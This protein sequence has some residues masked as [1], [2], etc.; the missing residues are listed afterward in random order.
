MAPEGAGPMPANA[1]DSG[2]P[3]EEVD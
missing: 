3:V 1:D 2:P